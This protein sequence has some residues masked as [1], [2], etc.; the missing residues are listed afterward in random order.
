MKSEKA[1]AEI[2]GMLAMLW[3]Q[4][5]VMPTAVLINT[6]EYRTILAAQ[7]VVYTDQEWEEYLNSLPEE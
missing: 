4:F 1:L 3:D 7:G 2:D 6:D 5:K